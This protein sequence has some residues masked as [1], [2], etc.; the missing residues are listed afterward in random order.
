L[1]GGD[2]TFTKYQGKSCHRQQ[3]Q[4]PE[5]VFEHTYLRQLIRYTGAGFM[6]TTHGIGFPSRDD[7]CSSGKLLLTGLI[8]AIFKEP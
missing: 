8:C 5:N 4:G 3:H 7:Y 2:K 1:S 6:P